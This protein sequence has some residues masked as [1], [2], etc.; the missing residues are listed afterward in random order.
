MNL[1][2]MV[3]S[4]GDA[5]WMDCKKLDLVLTFENIELHLHLEAW[6]IESLVV[7]CRA[8]VAKRV[9]TLNAVAEKIGA[10]T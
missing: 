3:Y 10:E 1:E 6:E 7:A 2:G 4:S 9:K 5:H 8:A